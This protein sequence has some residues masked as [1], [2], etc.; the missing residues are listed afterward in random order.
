MGIQHC[1]I[2]SVAVWN[3]EWADDGSDVEEMT[4]EERE[5]ADSAARVEI[6]K[7]LDEEAWYRE[8]ERGQM[9]FSPCLSEWGLK[10]MLLSSKRVA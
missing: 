2:E 9:H 4:E 8:Q 10:R 3:R 6:E 7:A 5:E 1:Y